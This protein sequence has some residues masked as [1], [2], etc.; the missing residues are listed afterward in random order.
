MSRFFSAIY[1]SPR[2][3]FCFC[4]NRSHY[5]ELTNTVARR[6]F[7]AAAVA[8]TTCVLER[9]YRQ[10]NNDTTITTTINTYNVPRSVLVSI[11]RFHKCVQSE[12][13]TAR[14]A[15]ITVIVTGPNPPR[16]SLDPFRSFRTHFITFDCTAA[17]PLCPRV[18]GAYVLRTR[19]RR[20]CRPVFKSD[21]RFWRII[22][23]PAAYSVQNGARRRQIAF[24][25]G[26]STYRTTWN[27]IQVG[28][29]P[30]KFVSKTTRSSFFRARP[31]RIFASPL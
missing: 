22:K 2:F 18:K 8:R 14:V 19:G 31:K 30:S 3:S 1:H 27:V 17:G 11:T 23:Y 20:E 6:I 29:V 10:E 5:G 7:H 12:R 28:R 26:A 4:F 24:I 13:P 25:I 15:V 21:F 16:F 9:R